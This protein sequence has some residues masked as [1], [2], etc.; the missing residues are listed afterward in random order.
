MKGKELEERMER[1]E[2]EKKHRKIHYLLS[3]SL[4]N[5]KSSSFVSNNIYY[6]IKRKLQ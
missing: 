4:S 2:R 1:S 6:F 3:Y 5:Y